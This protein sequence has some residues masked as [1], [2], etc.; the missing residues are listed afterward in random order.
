[1]SQAAY[2]RTLALP[3]RDFLSLLASLR[4]SDGNR[5]LVLAAF[6]LTTSPAASALSPRVYSG[7]SRFSLPSENLENI[8]VLAIS[9]LHC[10]ARNVRQAATFCGYAKAARWCPMTSERDPRIPH[11]GTVRLVKDDLAS[12]PG[13]TGFNGRY[14]TLVFGLF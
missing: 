2:S 4:E 8:D 1:M 9:N 13:T 12:G 3:F 5:L 7:A 14:A 10:I 6:D 11:V